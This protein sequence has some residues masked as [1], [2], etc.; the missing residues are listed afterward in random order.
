MVKFRPA[1]IAR[2]PSWYTVFVSPN[3]RGGG[4]MTSTAGPAFSQLQ[5]SDRDGVPDF[6]DNCPKAFNPDQRDSDADRIGDACDVD[7]DNDGMPDGET[8]A[9]QSLTGIKEI[10]MVTE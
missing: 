3:G 5:D 8:I 1:R 10:Q 6:V 9:Q 4:T 2:Y 7:D